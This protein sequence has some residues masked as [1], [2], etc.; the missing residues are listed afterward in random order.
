MFEISGSLGGLKTQALF[1]TESGWL[2][3][4]GVDGLS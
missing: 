1:M 4:S 3:C 2:W